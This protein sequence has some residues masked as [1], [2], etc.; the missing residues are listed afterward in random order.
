MCSLKPW[1][2]VS[3][4]HL[5]GLDQIQVLLYWKVILIDFTGCFKLLKHKPLDEGELEGRRTLLGLPL[6][7][8]T[9]SEP[10]VCF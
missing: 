9:D 5:I 3:E 4:K 8:T 1:G 2:L 10:L 6:E 7:E